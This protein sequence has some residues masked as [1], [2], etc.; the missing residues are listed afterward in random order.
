VNYLFPFH[1]PEYLNNQ[2]IKLTLLYKGVSSPGSDFLEPI[3]NGGDKS[4]I[5]LLMGY[6]GGLYAFIYRQT[7]SQEMED[8]SRLGAFLKV[9]EDGKT[10]KEMLD[11]NAYLFHLTQNHVL[12]WLERTSAGNTASSFLTWNSATDFVK[13]WRLGDLG[14]AKNNSLGGYSGHSR[15]TVI[16]DMG[17]GHRVSGL[18][19]TM[20]NIPDHPCRI[21]ILRTYS[22]NDG[23]A[24]MP[25]ELYAGNP[26]NNGNLQRFDLKAAIIARYFKFEID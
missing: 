23:I 3:A 19:I 12:H 24:W 14:F 6:K 15:K 9:Y 8:K 21:S 20:N 26:F 1:A 18:S 25:R 10:G 5:S 11:L 2:P 13:I 16:L 4:T 17:M 7:V 22:S